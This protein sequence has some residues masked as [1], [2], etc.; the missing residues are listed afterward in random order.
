M[1]MSDSDKSEAAASQQEV[2][3]IVRNGPSGA[4][5]VAGIAMAVVMAIYYAFYLFAYL[6][7]GIVR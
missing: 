4:F 1:A 5:A 3:R 2:D 7:R 6:P